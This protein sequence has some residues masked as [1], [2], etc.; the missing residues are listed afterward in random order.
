MRLKARL[1]GALAG[2]LR[3][4]PG[5]A[6]GPLAV[7]L[8]T[9][10][11]ASF[12][13]RTAL[14]N[15]ALAFPDWPARRRWRVAWASYVHTA[16]ALVE[17]LHTP[18][19][20]DDEIRERVVYEGLERVVEARREDRGI[21]LLTGHFGNWEW[22]AVRLDREGLPFAALYKAPRDE[23]LAER[24]VAARRA[25][26]IEAIEHDD[27]RAALGWLKRGGLLGIL[28]DQEP[29]RPDD[30]VVVPLFGRP[31][32]TY[33]GPFRLARAT[34]S[35]VFTVF[36]RRVAPG[37]YV[38]ETTPFELSSDPDPER[39]L[40]EDAAAFNARLEAVVRRDPEQWTWTYQR[41]KR[42]E[43]SAAGG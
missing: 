40:A 37:R 8:G 9:L 34:G 22:A 26:G 31:T 4:S 18:R 38:A 25:A 23:D 13:R 43:R 10:L 5:W 19:A 3:R 2:G 21:V 16:R 28:M 42:L 32:R 7:V 20:P 29:R 27:V 12:E 36:C 24:L 33:V 6:E 17:F 39:A 11:M 1:A 35:A 14:E 15:L 30:G 41:W